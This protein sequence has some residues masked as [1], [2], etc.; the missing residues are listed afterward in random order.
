M[1]NRLQ[2]TLTRIAPPLRSKYA[3]TD[4]APIAPRVVATRF[5]RYFVI[6]ALT[7]LL[8][9]WALMRQYERS[10]ENAAVAEELIHL[11]MNERLVQKELFD[12][13]ASFNIM[14]HVP[15]MQAFLDTPTA[16]RRSILAHSLVRIAEIYGRFTQ[17]RIFDTTGREMLGVD[18]DQGQIR[19]FAEGERSALPDFRDFHRAISLPPGQVHVS[20]IDLKRLDGTP[21]TPVTPVIHFATPLFDSIDDKRGLLVLTYSAQGLLDML[22]P[23]SHNA[24]EHHVML[25]NEEGYWLVNNDRSYEWGW[26]LDQHDRSFA[27]RHPDIWPQIA[28]RDRG[29]FRTGQG[30]FLLRTLYPLDFGNATTGRPALAGKLG[31]SPEQLLNY[32]WKQVIFVPQS[33]LVAKSFFRHST[34]KVGI[35]LMLLLLATTSWIMAN[36]KLQ[37][38]AYLAEKKR[39][40]HEFERQAQS[41]SLTGISNRRHF[42]ALGQRELSRI[43]RQ[44]GTLSALALDIDYFKRINDRYGH[45]TGDQVLKAV[46]DFCARQLRENDVFA[47][48]GGEEFAIVLPD[49][50]VETAAQVAG[51]LREGVE[52]L[53]VALDSEETV[54]LTISIG[55][56]GFSGPE[57]TLDSLLKRA[58][59][60]LYAAKGSGRN[61]VCIDEASPA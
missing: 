23:D 13:S 58:D 27:K 53:K 25:I 44:N 51:R 52:K 15:I 57:D 37:K 5:V 35:A 11:D 48:M 3:L 4:A 34:G 50:G 8:P 10:Q 2:E 46:A 59:K 43:R 1:P 54:S 40:A 19:V 30:I 36:L 33:S 24:E 20:P 21:E 60:A 41:D 32:R 14:A 55:I 38:E 28:D 22:R 16:E 56:A 17:I 42:N 6:T 39:Q 26:L 31:I 61:R 9:G 7:F 12:V 29:E 49:T 18:Y 45:H 47:R